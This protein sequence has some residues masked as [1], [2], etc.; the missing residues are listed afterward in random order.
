ML[1]VLG[2]SIVELLNIVHCKNSLVEMTKKKKVKKVDLTEPNENGCFK[3]KK[4]G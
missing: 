3:L 1:F 2:Q 4:N